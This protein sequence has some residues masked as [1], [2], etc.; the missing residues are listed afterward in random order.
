[1]IRNIGWRTL[2]CM[3]LV[4]AC[5]SDPV[6]GGR[7]FT[8]ASGMG[9]GAGGAGG[10]GMAGS[11]GSAGTAGVGEPIGGS[12]GLGGF[13]GLGGEGGNPEECSGVSE[14][15]ENMVQPV[16]IIFGIDTSG[17]MGEE[18]SFVQQNL[19][20][21]SQQIIDSGV[22]VRVI[23]LATEG[24]A[25]MADECIVFWP[26]TPCIPVSGDNFGVCIGAPLG[27]GTCPADSNPPVYQ[28]VPVEIGSNDVLNIFIS[29]Y[30]QYS[31]FLRPGSLKHFVSI[32]DDD[33]TDGPYNNADAFIAAVAA[34]DPDPAMW[35]T[36][37]YSSIYCFTECPAAAEVGLVHQDLVAKTMGV[38]G[39]LC[40]QDFGPVFEKLATEVAE[41]VQLACE[42]EIPP[43]PD[44]ETF[45]SNKTNVE[46]ML[47][48]TMELLPRLPTGM[49][50]CADLAA[51]RYDDEASPT[52]VLACPAACTRIQ[53]ATNASVKIVFGCDTVPLV[54]E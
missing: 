21:F 3:V 45:D 54:V 7:G 1:M 39:D 50:D 2:A 34:L 31:Q 52:K 48:S 12:S 33:A 28:H 37:S 24:T 4:S 44:D 13:G 19:N 20:T 32:T 16:D 17:S 35:A 14:T 38:G 10:T 36:W 23:M 49:T 46:L 26:G 15:A 27:S 47:D 6:T 11:A 22:D 18:I 42:W 41:S 51:W 40:L 30:P 53:S 8:G 25:D 9:A 5:S 43:P 29:S